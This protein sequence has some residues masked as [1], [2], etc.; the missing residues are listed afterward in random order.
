MKVFFPTKGPMGEK[1]EPG[2]TGPQGIDGPQ[3]TEVCVVVFLVFD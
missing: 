2:A 3:G 1:G